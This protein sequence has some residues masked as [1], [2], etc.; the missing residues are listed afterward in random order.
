M[1]TKVV[2]R[3]QSIFNRLSENAN[4]A[5]RNASLVSDRLKERKIS[6]VS[7]FVGILLNEDCIATKVIESMGL[8][9]GEILKSF[10]EGKVFEITGDTSVKRELSFSVEAQEVFREAFNHAQRMSHV[11]VGTEHLMLAILR[12]KNLKLDRLNEI[13]LTYATFRRDLSKVAMY[14]VGILAKPE[15]MQAQMQGEKVVDM[16]GTDLVELGREGLLDPVIGRDEEISHLINILS[17]RKKNNP[18]IVGEAGVGKSVLVEALAQQIADGNVPPSLRNMK[19]ILL[20]VASI[21]AGSRMRGDVEERV[22]AIVQEV[23][24]SNDTILFIDEIH[25]IVSPG[26]PGSSSDIASIL[27]PALLQ[28]NFRCIGATTLEE[29]TMYFEEDNALD[30]RFQTIFLKE[31]SIED[32]LEILKNIKPILENHHDLRIANEALKVAV[33][34]SDRYVTDRY[35]PDKAI[36][37]LD[38]AAAS[39]RL[40]IESSFKELSELIAELHDIR[41][42]KDSEILKGKMESALDMQKREKRLERKIAK[43]EKEC[44]RSK[45]STKNEVSAED[46]R[47]IISKWTGIPLNTLGG[48]ERTALLNLED[49]LNSYVIGQE[50]AC[51]SV[52]FA[53][54]RA[55]TGIID[56]ERPW[57]SFLF[58]GPTG[59]GKTEL[60]KVLTRELFGNE[61]R[62]IQID[63]SEMME[64]HSVSK[65][66]GSPPGYIGFQQGGWLTEKVRREP[67]SVILFDEVEK[68]HGDVLNILLQI[69]EY[70]HLTDGRGRRVNFKNTV[71]ILTSNIGA[72]EIGKDKVLGFVGSKGKGKSDSEIDSAY[73]SMKKV[74]LD[75]LRGEL[76]P[77]LINRLDDIVIFRSLNRK[78]ARKIVKLLVKELNERLV[79]EKVV[80]SLDSKAITYVIKN[81][82]SEEYGARPLRRFLQDKV[83]NLLADWMLENS[84][85]LEKG[86]KIKIEMGVKEDNIIIINK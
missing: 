29:Y 80:V 30:R 70:G 49:T 83:E 71:V 69:L 13:N 9:R 63:M 86:K 16:L 58:L 41:S 66:I 18:L 39:K 84:D 57:A 77:E 10:F 59:V 1:R 53:I 68:A 6:V 25:N 64:M 43:M 8:D 73:S 33:T 40:M 38:E 79:E 26:I 35:L 47:N 19:I 51:S 85:E 76:R 3:K 4:V 7:I 28:D 20:D 81:S 67:H 44:S 72:E 22:M 46:I 54:K 55:R 15:E 12:S 34:L 60:A 24:S 48:K 32:T 61:D 21:M 65:L 52:A 42:K 23:I 50:D 75:E 2:K 5:L 78:D 45:K 27:K 14:P 37:L 36:D 11:Y 17:R 31:T 82:F 56:A 62:L 74:L